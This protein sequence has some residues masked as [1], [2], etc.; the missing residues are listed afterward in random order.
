M[1][2]NT[3]AARRRAIFRT[4][5]RFAGA[6]NPSISG[7]LGPNPHLYGFVGDN[8]GDDPVLNEAISLGRFTRSVSNDRLSIETPKTSVSLKRNADWVRWASSPLNLHR[9]TM[10]LV[11]RLRQ[12]DGTYLDQ[13]LLEGLSR[14]PEFEGGAINFSLYDTFGELFGRSIPRDR[15]TIEDWPFARPEDVNKPYPIIYGKV[16]NKLDS[17]PEP[18]G[19]LSSISGVQIANFQGAVSSGGES[20]EGRFYYAIAP[21]LDDIVLAEP[22]VCFV[23]IVGDDQKLELTWDAYA[24]PGDK[25]RIWQS[26]GSDFNFFDVYGSRFGAP[27]PL[28]NDIDA[29]EVGVTILTPGY[30]ATR[31][32][33][34]K[35]PTLPHEFEQDWPEKVWYWVTA[36]VAG[37]EIISQP[38]VIDLKI[39]NFRSQR[40]VTLTWPEVDGATSIKVRRGH[41][42]YRWNPWLE[43]EWDLPGNATSIIDW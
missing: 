25:L 31:D 5:L 22:V 28:A 35:A 2:F 38:V 40:Y 26:G 27:G 37:A 3:E 6:D 33:A 30:G 15:V 7:V 18:V 14:E 4:F 24:G 36:T 20:R 32:N 34:P 23:D 43:Y 11:G 39:T 8:V 17:V 42:V 29:S 13:T 19:A 21:V 9:R 10:K 1:S 16:E 12:D 41:S